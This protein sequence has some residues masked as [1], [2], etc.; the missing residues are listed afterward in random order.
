LSELALE[1]VGVPS[2]FAAVAGAATF[3]CCACW[4]AWMSCEAASEGLAG[5]LPADASGRLSCAVG[6]TEAGESTDSAETACCAPV[7]GGVFAD[8]GAAALLSVAV[9][10]VV[11]ASVV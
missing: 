10:D 8:F 9:T 6:V 3:L 1:A 2:A 5:E 7:S 11:V 4:T